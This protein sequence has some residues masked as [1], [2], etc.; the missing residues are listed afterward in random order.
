MIRFLQLMVSTLHVRRV[1]MFL[2][3]PLCNPT[4][5]QFTGFRFHDTTK[6][7]GLGATCFDLKAFV[8]LAPALEMKADLWGTRHRMM[9]VLGIENT[10][11]CTTWHLLLPR[12]SLLA[13]GDWHVSCAL[14]TM[15]LRA[16]F[17]CMSVNILCPPQVGETMLR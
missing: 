10:G 16:T 8:C 7:P 14:E 4:D 11:S 1:S 5:P 3:A 17:E 13:N 6:D 2:H 12:D 9:E 15:C